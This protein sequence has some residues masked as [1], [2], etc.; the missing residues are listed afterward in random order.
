MIDR[1]NS[2]VMGTGVVGNIG[3]RPTLA[4]QIPTFQVKL[5]QAVAYGGLISGVL[6]ATN[7]VVAFGLYGMNPIQVLQFIASGAFGP[8][9]FEYGLLSAAAGAGFHFVI[10]FVAATV[11]AVAAWFVPL[12]RRNW[13][14]AGLLYGAWVWAFMNLIVLPFTAVVPGPTGI[15]LTLNG[16][17]GHAL[18]VGLPIAYF[19][20]RVG[21]NESA[22]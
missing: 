8:A 14:V 6:D 15:G 4:S 7:G 9:S 10:A 3:E 11:F 18:L 17:I 13:V 20:R 2:I 5:L 1:A 22:E 12:L 19:S 16:I 21:T